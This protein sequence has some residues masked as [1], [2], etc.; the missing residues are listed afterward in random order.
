[1]EMKKIVADAKKRRAKFLAEFTRTGWTVQ[2]MA[3]KYGMTRSRM[4]WMLNKAK[5]EQ[6]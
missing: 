3:D 6:A 5:G 1:M 4:S 2:K